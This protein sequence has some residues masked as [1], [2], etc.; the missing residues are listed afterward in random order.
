V[1]T[2]AAFGLRFG[3][4]EVLRPIIAGAY[5]RRPKPPLELRRSPRTLEVCW[6]L[7]INSKVAA[8]AAEGAL[9]CAGIALRDRSE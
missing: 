9:A 7:Q 3:R 1:L 6:T 2:V 4:N 5:F 8:E